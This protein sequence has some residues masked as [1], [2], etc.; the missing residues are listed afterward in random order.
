MI[1]LSALETALYDLC[2]KILGVSVSTLLGGGFR[3]RVPVYLTGGYPHDLSRIVE[4]V[5]DES[6]R[7]VDQGAGALKLKVGFGVDLDTEL[8]H[9]VRNAVGPSVR[10]MMDA[11]RA[12]TAAEAIQLSK[13]VQDC[14]IYW[15]EEPVV[16][17]DLEGYREVRARTEIPVAGGEEEY[18]RWGFRRLLES[19]A[20]DIVQPSV[21]MAGGVGE[22][23]NIAYLASA[24]NTRCVP[25]SWGLGINTAATLQLL[26]AMPQY[27]PRLI[28]DPPMLEVDSSASSLRDEALVDGPVIKDGFAYLPENPGIGAVVNQ[29]AV[30]RIA[31]PIRE[32][33]L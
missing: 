12:Y 15:F 22:C 7:K 21:A 6:R 29:S 27:P 25:H 5:V 31:S 30:E 1:A 24:F 33:S 10:I 8:I 17:E 16:P 20:V 3:T 13:R 18:T 14:R 4:E 9:A 2:G 26:S 32:S 11:N 28:E 19:G 23:R